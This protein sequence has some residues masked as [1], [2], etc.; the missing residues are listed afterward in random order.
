MYTVM[1]ANRATA[2]RKRMGRRKA[3]E[4]RGKGIKEK[5]KEKRGCTCAVEELSIRRS[6]ART[7]RKESILGRDRKTA[8]DTLLYLSKNHVYKNVEPQI[9]EKIRTS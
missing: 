2:I 6:E 3:G 7:S 8:G 4:R 1:K 5:Q 9:G